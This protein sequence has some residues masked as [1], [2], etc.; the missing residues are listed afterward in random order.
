MP[1]ECEESQIKLE[2]ETPQF[3]QSLFAHNEKVLKYLEEEAGVKI[4]TRDGWLLAR[5]Y[6]EDCAIVEH[7]FGD[8][9]EARRNG[10]E[11]TCLL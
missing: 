4:V 7:V 6:P 8:L 1:T 3:L 9:E 11:I 2:F 5:G 10:G